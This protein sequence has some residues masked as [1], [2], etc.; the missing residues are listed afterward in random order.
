MKRLSMFIVPVL[1]I[2]MLLVGVVQ[3]TTASLATRAG[4]IAGSGCGA[5][6]AVGGI[7]L[8][9]PGLELGGVAVLLAGNGT[10]IVWALEQVTG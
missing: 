10:C 6:L 4:D 5:T 3:P 8:A 9:T 1:A 7:L 2:A